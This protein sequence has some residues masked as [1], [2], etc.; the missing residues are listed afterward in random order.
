MRKPPARTKQQS[1]KR[2]AGPAPQARRGSAPRRRD[3]SA[4]PASVEGFSLRNLVARF[5]AKL[6]R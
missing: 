1:R 6:R 3:T 2:R 4:Q 5:L